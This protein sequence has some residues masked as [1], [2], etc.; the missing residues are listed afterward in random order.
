MTWLTV[1]MFRARIM[2]PSAKALERSI[3]DFEVAGPSGLV[4]LSTY[5]G[6]VCLIVNVA[7][8]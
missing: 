3:F 7:S 4:P 2:K 1:I 5:R 6:K 8:K